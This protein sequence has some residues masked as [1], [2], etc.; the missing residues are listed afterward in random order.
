MA[1]EP[2]WRLGRLKWALNPDLRL[3]LVKLEP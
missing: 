1:S 3:E 2:L